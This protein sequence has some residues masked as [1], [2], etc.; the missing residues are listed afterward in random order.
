MSPKR[1]SPA[2][3]ADALHGWE[4]E[5]TISATGKPRIILRK[6]DRA[7]ITV[8]RAEATPDAVALERGLVTALEQEVAASSPDDRD[9]WEARRDQA[10]LAR[11]DA[12]AQRVALAAVQRAREARDQE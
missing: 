9:L 1:E 12:A 11:D 10:I 5:H 2:S 3:D 7:E 6:A 4:V 8:D